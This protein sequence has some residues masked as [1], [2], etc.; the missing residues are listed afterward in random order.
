M[1]AEKVFA[2]WR[3]T[4]RAE[5]TAMLDAGGLRKGD[6]L[7]VRAVGDLGKGGEAKRIQKMVADIGATIEVLPAAE[8]RQRGRPPRM[9]P[10]GDQKEHLCRLWY[11]PAPLSHV[12]MRAS[13][14]MGQD[15]KRDQLYYICG[16]RDGSRKK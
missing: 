5:L 16:P 10:T 6:V 2:D 12:L 14:I 1:G 9:S 8:V 15:V 11:S 13:D 4:G 7:C 3:G